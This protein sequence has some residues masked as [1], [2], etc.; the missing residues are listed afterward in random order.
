MV[1]SSRASYSVFEATPEDI[2]NVAVMGASFYAEGSLPGGFREE[3]FVSSWEKILATGAGRIFVLDRDM[4]FCGALG[5]LIFPDM[6]D[7]A[8]VAMELFWYVMP[9]H[10][11]HG[12]ML[13]E[14]FEDWG[15]ANAISRS[16]IAHFL[17]IN[18]EAMGKLYRRKGYRAIETNYVKTF[19]P[20]LSEPQQH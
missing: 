1:A 3:V 2:R 17:T 15:R 16:I 5:A 18:P 12:L 7:G 8:K 9:Q 13:M 20:C 14:A 4:E 11:G 10:R 6:N 19:T